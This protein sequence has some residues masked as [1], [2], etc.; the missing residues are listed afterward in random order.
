MYL[1]SAVCYL[2]LIIQE[3]FFFLNYPELHMVQLISTHAPWVWKQVGVLLSMLFPLCLT[4]SVTVCCH[5][6]LCCIA[7][8]CNVSSS[9]VLR[10]EGIKNSF[11]FMSFCTCCLFLIL[12]TLLFKRWKSFF[13]HR[14]SDSIRVKN[15]QRN[16]TV[17]AVS[18][19]KKLDRKYKHISHHCPW[20]KCKHL[21]SI[22]IAK[23]YCILCSSPWFRQKAL[24]L[25]SCSL[26]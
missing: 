23:L 6:V 8:I 26:C 11:V 25:A 14:I 21:I 17:V 22:I 7:F 24:W 9:K 1:V 5:Y 12:Q 13:I 3:T 18:F 19:L 2:L 15:F 20:G 10:G 4:S 16:E